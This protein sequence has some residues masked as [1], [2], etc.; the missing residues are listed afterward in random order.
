MPAIDISANTRIPQLIHLMESVRDFRDPNEL[1]RAFVNGLNRAYSDRAYVQISTRGLKPG[2]YQIQRILSEDGV[3]LIDHGL[4]LLAAPLS[5]GGV[6]GQITATSQPQL[7]HNVDLRHEPPLD[8]RLAPYRSLIAV[9]VLKN[10]FAIDW[11][12]LL[13]TQPCAFTEQDLEDLIMRANLLSMMATNLITSNQLRLANAHIQA[14]MEQI[15]R[16]QRALLPDHLPKIPGLE[17][18]TSYHTFDVVGGDLYDFAAFRKDGQINDDRWAFL[19]GDV[20]GHGPAAAVVMAMFHAIIHTYPD[21]PKGPGEV[22]RHVNRHLFAKSIDNSFVTAFLAFYEPRTRE[23]I[24]ARAGHNPPLLKEFPHRGQARQLDAVG[25]IPLGIMDDVQYSESSVILHPGQTLILY[26][27]GI[28]EAKRPGGEMFG[29]E[30]IERSLIHCSGAPECA[31]S[32]ITE[33][34]KEHQVNIRPND[35]Q[36]VVVMQVV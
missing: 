3:D 31:I 35:D 26:T 2:E 8:G 33:A 30:G 20:S 7:L 4:N 6:L 34:L 13:Q 10:D 28:T 24:Y 22:L 23:L 14:E 32:H 19:I 27:D 18:A 25:E 17:I 29:V 36:T 1:V 12:A 15:A 5:H 11:V 21:N 16:I 9:P